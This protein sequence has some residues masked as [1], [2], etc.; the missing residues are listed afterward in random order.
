MF[1]CTWVCRSLSVV[2]LVRVHNLLFAFICVHLLLCS[3]G[4]SRT[5]KMFAVL[6]SIYL[7][8]QTCVFFQ[9]SAFYF[10]VLSFSRVSI[11]WCL[12]LTLSV[13][14]TNCLHVLVRISACCFS[15]ACLL[16][17]VFFY[18]ICFS[19]HS[20]CVFYPWLCACTCAHFCVLCFSSES[21]LTDVFFYLNCLLV[22]VRISVCGLCFSSACLLPDVF[23]TGFLV[24]LLPIACLYLCVYLRVVFLVR[25]YYLMFSSTWI[26]CV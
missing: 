22:L 14:C 26:V 7:F 17:D 1:A 21:L 10:C 3:S 6:V 16:P 18:F 9:T 11:T 15:S 19:S 5:K 8:Y 20:K 24:C 4:V 23:F 13:S 12:R 25:V 2:F